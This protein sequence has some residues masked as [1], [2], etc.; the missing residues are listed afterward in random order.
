MQQ[1]RSRDAQSPLAFVARR[2]RH[3]SDPAPMGDDGP[4]LGP[5]RMGPSGSHRMA[6]GADVPAA[7]VGTGSRE[8]LSWLA[9]REQQ[10]VTRRA[11]WLM[12]RSSKRRLFH[13]VRVI[14]EYPPSTSGRELS[15]LLS[16]GLRPSLF[17]YRRHDRDEFSL[18]LAFVRL[19]YARFS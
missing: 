7:A 11:R 8:S 15:A 19:H 14:W 2:Q 1:L 12:C 17:R 13:L 9:T 6:T 4:A 18:T 5:L 16:V 10:P 3:P